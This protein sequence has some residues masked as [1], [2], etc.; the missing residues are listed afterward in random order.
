MLRRLVPTAI[1]DLLALG[2]L[3][4]VLQDLAYRS[5][6]AENEPHPLSLSTTYSLFVRTFR[7]TGNTIQIPNGLVS[8]PALDWVQVVV[9]SL[10]VVNGLYVFS[11]LRGSS[12]RRE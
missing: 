9:A 3:Y 10:I 12:K 11:R 2:I 4:F 6:F 1:F 7:I 8:P 5:S